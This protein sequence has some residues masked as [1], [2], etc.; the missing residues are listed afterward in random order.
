MER[1]ERLEKV[2]STKEGWKMKKESTR[3]L[4][5]LTYDMRILVFGEESRDPIDL[6]EIW[7][8]TC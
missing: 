1:K 3:R 8:N 7:R 2:Q 5:Q 4:E 6:I